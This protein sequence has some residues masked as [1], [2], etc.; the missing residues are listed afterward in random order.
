MKYHALIWGKG[1]KKDDLKFLFIFK[2]NRL[3]V[4]KLSN[5]S[6]VTFTL[7][8]GKIIQQTIFWFF[9]IPR[10][11]VLTFHVNY[12]LRRQFAWNFKPCFSKEKMDFNWW[13]AECA[14]GVL[15]VCTVVAP[16]ELQDCSEWVIIKFYC[17]QASDACQHERIKLIP[18]RTSVFI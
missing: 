10:K 12:L 17:R 5:T 14:K 15:K 6:S 3:R 1:R 4:N 16:A 13:P 7:G 8:T 18:C 9:F 11:W 2:F